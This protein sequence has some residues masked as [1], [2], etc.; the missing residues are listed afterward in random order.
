MSKADELFEELEYKKMTYPSGYIFYYQLNGLD[1]KFGFE[2]QED[3][4]DKTK[5]EVY[6]V[7]YGKNDEAI[8]FN[9]KEL[10]AINLKCRELGWIGGE[11]E[12]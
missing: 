2:F 5:S 3:K 8:T 11:D 12:V 1:K 6:P 9:M 4:Y 10:E 7:C